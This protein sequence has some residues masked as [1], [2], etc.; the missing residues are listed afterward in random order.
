MVLGKMDNYMQKNQTGL[1]S[2]IT[3]KI[4]SKW[5]KTLNV[6]PG[7]IKFPEENIG[8]DLLDIGLEIYFGSYSEEG[9][10]EQK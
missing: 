3:L 1:V 2:Y 9:Q 4:N 10:Q 8:G 6:W 7:T 5:I